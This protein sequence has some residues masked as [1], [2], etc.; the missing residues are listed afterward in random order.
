[1]RACGLTTLA[2]LVIATAC[3]LLLGCAAK[4]PGPAAQNR[5]PPN[6]PGCQIEVV[7]TDAGLGERVARLEG[8]LTADQPSVTYLFT[9]ATG[10]TLRLR[11]SGPAAS[12]MLT[13]PNGQ[14]TAPPLPADMLL[15]AK[16]KYV[17]RVAANTTAEDAYGAFQMELR[18]IGKP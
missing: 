13:R 11:M 2:G 18:V 6:Q 9:A 5:C 8:T 4:A 14:S 16:G 1:M 12:L 7:F 3:S 17:L 10:E 15:D